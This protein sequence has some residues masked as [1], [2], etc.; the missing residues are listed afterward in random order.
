MNVGI[1]GCGHVCEQHLRV[2]RGLRDVKIVGVCDRDS[3]KTSAVARA[4]GPLIA[5]GDLSQ[6]ID[7]TRPDVVHVL[8]PPKNHR[9]HA[10]EAMESGCHVL[11]EKPMAM[12]T[13]RGAGNA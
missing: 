8:T 4:Y 11:V 10:V 3:E 5:F 1:L 6:M 13:K 2:L 9:A 7:V 12:N